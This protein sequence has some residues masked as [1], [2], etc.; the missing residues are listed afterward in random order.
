MRLSLPVI[1]CLIAALL[2]GCASDEDKEKP[3]HRTNKKWYQG[4]MDTEDRNFFIDSFFNG[5]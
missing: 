4:D 1:A 5:R 3:W 2:T